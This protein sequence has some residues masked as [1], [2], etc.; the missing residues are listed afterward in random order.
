[1]HLGHLWVALLASVFTPNNSPMYIRLEDITAEVICNTSPEKQKEYAMD[2]I[3]QTNRFGIGNAGAIWQSEREE[4][5]KA[6]QARF[7]IADWKRRDNGWRYWWLGKDEPDNYRAE[8]HYYDTLTRV[9][10]DHDFD[11]GLII[12]GIELAPDRE[13]YFCMWDT[14]YPDTLPQDKPNYFF[15]PPVCDPIGEKVSKSTGSKWVLR[16]NPD[17]ETL[18]T[19]M[20]LARHYLIP[21]PAWTRVEALSHLNDNNSRALSAVWQVIHTHPIRPDPTP[22]LEEEVESWRMTE[23]ERI[24][25]YMCGLCGDSQWGRTVSCPICRRRVCPKCELEKRHVH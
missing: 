3:V 15:V 5:Y 2:F 1:M 22:L 23:Q 24:V 10:D 8:T 18:R 4:A 13:P 11:I 16:D 6:V 25:Y 21:T 9:V 14:L 12:H 19:L 20:G 17:L 7:P